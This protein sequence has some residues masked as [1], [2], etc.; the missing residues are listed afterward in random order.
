MEEI[1]PFTPLTPAAVPSRERF[2]SSI[3]TAEVP[4]RSSSSASPS[5][6]LSPAP[7]TENV[8]VGKAP[9]RDFLVGLLQEGSTTESADTI[10]ADT[11]DT[12]LSERDETPAGISS[13]QI[14]TRFRLTTRDRRNGRRRP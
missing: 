3:Q 2:P 9:V 11:S 8:A 12:D 1:Y 6:S 4:A 5:R 14:L 10:S 13:S 7:S